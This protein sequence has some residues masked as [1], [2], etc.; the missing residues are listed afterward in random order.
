VSRGAA[1]VRR[2]G[3]ADLEALSRLW[4]QISQHH[5]SFDPL[6]RL[7]SGSDAEIRSLLEDQL[8]DPD[9]AAFV[10]ESGEGVWGMAMVR[11]D[12]APPILEEVERAEITDLGVEPDWRRRGVATQLVRVALGWIR[13]RGVERVEVRVA[14]GNAEGQAFWR[15][16]GFGPHMQIL[17]RR[18]GAG[19]PAD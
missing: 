7:R 2:A 9:A 19:T 17:Q 13:A 3:S 18:I 4:I 12:R 1:R 6:F 10:C 5:A 16:L 15:A 11:I 14:A 8:S